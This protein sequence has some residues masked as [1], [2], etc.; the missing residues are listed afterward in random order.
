MLIPMDA[1]Y[2]VNAVHLADPDTGDPESGMPGLMLSA[3]AVVRLTCIED[4][5]VSSAPDY[6]TLTDWRAG[7]GDWGGNC[8][9]AG[10][11]FGNTTSWPAAD[12]SAGLIGFQISIG[13]NVAADMGTAEAA[14]YCMTVSGR[15]AAGAQTVVA[16]F[17]VLVR[18]IVGADES[19]SSLNSSSSSSSESSE[20]STP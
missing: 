5:N 4:G 17:P 20:S 8:L 16:T 6:S 15:N 11:D 14:S 3:N 13:A 9:E 12:A 2:D 19:S 1:C 18:N 7:L 10:T